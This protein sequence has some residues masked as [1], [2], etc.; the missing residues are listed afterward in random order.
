MRTIERVAEAIKRSALGTGADTAGLALATH[1]EPASTNEIAD[2]Q[3]SNQLSREWLRRKHVVTGFDRCV[4]TEAFMILTIQVSQKLREHGWNTLAVTS[5]TNGEGKTVTA[6]NLAISLAM[7]HK[8][9]AIIVDADLRAPRIREYFQLPPGPG[10]S[11]YLTANTPIQELLIHPGIENLALLP[12][13]DPVQRSSEILGSYKMAELMDELKTR[14]SSRI[15]VLDLPSVLPTAD[16]LA[17]APYLDA[18][19]LVVEEGKTRRQDVSRAA[20]ALSST[21][22]IGTVLNKASGL[23][24]LH[25]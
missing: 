8:Q 24:T 6:I 17:C 15:V 18:A 21:Q 20:Q 10:V 11:D 1:A 3:G 25:R 5:P 23:A 13:G 2:T 14:Y 22:L 19:L 16:V 12:G 9:T 4:F 7:Q